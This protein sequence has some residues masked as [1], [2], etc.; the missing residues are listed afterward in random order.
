MSFL[1]SHVFSSTKLEN[2]KV[3]QVPGSQGGQTMYTH[4]SECKND[5]IKRKRETKSFLQ[6]WEPAE[7]IT[8]L[9]PLRDWQLLVNPKTLTSQERPRCT[10]DRQCDCI[11]YTANTKLGG[12]SYKT[13]PF[14]L[15]GST[16]LIS[17]N[18]SMFKLPQ[19]CVQIQGSYVFTLCCVFG[20]SFNS[21]TTEL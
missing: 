20:C 14:P 4:V 21:A 5:K 1:L 13:T 8:S 7:R 12:L 2:K 19:F 16:H 18:Y 15:I 9:P 6:S 10:A 17:S 11:T 3:E